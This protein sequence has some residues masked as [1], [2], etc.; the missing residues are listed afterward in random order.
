[1]LPSLPIKR[2][3]KDSLHHGEVP[4]S[5]G[6]PQT[7]RNSSRRLGVEEAKQNKLR[8][9]QWIKFNRVLNKGKGFECADKPSLML[10]NKKNT[11]LLVGM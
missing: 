2:K 11:C 9:R 7:P 3:L 1:M 8:R 4:E 6:H 5:R 10:N